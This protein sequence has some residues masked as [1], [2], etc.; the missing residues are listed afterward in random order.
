M[1]DFLNYCRKAQKASC[2]STVY[3]L[4]TEVLSVKFAVFDLLVIYFSLSL[5]FFYFFSLFLCI[6]FV[7]DYLK[8]AENAIF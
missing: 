1:A 5:F 4:F 2:Q 6:R 8:W 7:C 3:S